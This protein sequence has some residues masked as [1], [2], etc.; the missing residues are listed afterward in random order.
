MPKFPSLAS[1]K[2]KGLSP[3]LVDSETKIIKQTNPVSITPLEGEI[4]G[5]RFFVFLVF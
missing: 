1:G 5:V 2:D 4:K 3:D